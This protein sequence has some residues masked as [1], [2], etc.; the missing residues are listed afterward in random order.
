M[1]RTSRKQPAALQTAVAR[2][3]RTALYARLSVEDSGHGN[4]DSIKMQE[5]L[6]REYVNRQPDLL[7]VCVYT[8]N[9]ATGTNFDRPGFEEMM[10]SVRRREIDCIVVKDLSR[11]GRNYVETGFYLEKIF[12]FLGVRFIAVNDHYDTLKSSGGDEMV[13]SLKNIV[14]SLFAKD[15]SKKVSAAL[16]IK[17][18]KGEYLGA[19]TPYGYLKSPEDKHKLIIDPETAPTVADIF[20]WRLQG[21]GYALIARKLNG[22]EIPSPNR[23]RYLRGEYKTETPARPGR[24]W[25]SQ[26]VK[27]I[28]NNMVYMGHTAQGKQIRSLHDGIP[29]TEQD[30]ENWIIVKNTHQPI[31]R[32]ED[33]QK[34]QD[35]NELR[36]AEAN[37]SRGKHPKTENILRG[38]IDCGGCGSRMYRKKNLSPKGPPRYTYFCPNYSQNNTIAG[39]TKKWVGEPELFDVILKGIQIQAAASAATEALAQKFS[40]RPEHRTKATELEKKR[41]SIHAEIA[42]NA[43]RRS[44]LF[45]NYASHLLTAEEYAGLKQQYD[46]Q[47]KQLDGRLNAILNQQEIDG[48]T[49]SPQ[50]AWIGAFQKSGELKALNRAVVLELIHRITIEDDYT[51]HIAWN[52]RDEYEPLI[53][54][55]RGEAE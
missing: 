13:V 15:I 24:L 54:C 21:M 46:A 51:I 30:K 8:D 10:E 27:V 47:A 25:Q 44:A 26:T 20:S 40:S 36:K 45:E 31:I 35:I 49:L 2:T 14:N 1:A 18:E 9:G 34:V 3:Y 5:Y 16:H 6:L 53:S 41:K 39:C 42:K 7:L 32:E 12:P 29:P 55:S 43:L 17:Q 22:L 33:F 11:F 37:K 52:F 19:R 38:L 28:L 23:L 48:K 50:N 4:H